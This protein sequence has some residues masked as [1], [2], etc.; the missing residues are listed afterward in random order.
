MSDPLQTSRSAFLRKLSEEIGSHRRRRTFDAGLHQFLVIGAAIAGFAALALGL[1][2]KNSPEHATWAAWAGATGALTSVATILLQ[3]LHCVKAVNWHDR[4][5]VELDVIRDKFLFKH[6]SAPS[7]AELAELVEEVAEL[8]MRML[9]AW[10][11]IVSTGLSAFGRIK[12]PP[13]G[14]RET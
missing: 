10:E 13:K 9:D 3:Q 8:K 4:M 7:E 5:A 2:A 14:Q 6:N 11:R 12:R 1:I